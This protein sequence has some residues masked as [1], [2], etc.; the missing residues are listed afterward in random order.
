MYDHIGDADKCAKYAN[1]CNARISV[2]SHSWEHIGYYFSFQIREMNQMIGRFEFESVLQRSE[3]LVDALQ[4]AKDLFS[5]IDSDSAAGKPQQ[6]DLLGKVYGIRLEAYINLLHD[7]PEY[8]ADALE[9]SDLALAEFSKPYDL[10]RQ[11]QL[12]CLLHVTA[13][14]E[15][16]TLESLLK[17]YDL[18]DTPEAFTKFIEKAFASGSKA[19]TFAIMHYT[20]VMVLLKEK[21]DPRAEQMKDCLMAK[22]LFHK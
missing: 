2:V 22:Y 15:H 7:H 3:P 20:N 9:N 4:S 17:A 14:K 19:D 21:N 11:Y 16:E 5:M 12:R 13:E 1:R 10:H 8:Y 18:N 6:S